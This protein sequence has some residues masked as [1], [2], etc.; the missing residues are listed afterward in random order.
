MGCHK[1]KQKCK[2]AVWVGVEEEDVVRRVEMR[3]MGVPIGNQSGP[4][5]ELVAEVQGVRKVL[6]ELVGVQ[7]EYGGRKR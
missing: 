6:E 3:V 7:R 1:A 2:G 4:L 5:A